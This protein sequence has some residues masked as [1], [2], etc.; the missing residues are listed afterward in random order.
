RYKKLRPRTSKTRS[1]MKLLMLRHGQ[2]EMF[3]ASDAARQL[4]DAG[5]AEVR[6][7][8]RKSEK[9]L[10]EV[11]QMWVSPLLRAQQ[12]ADLVIEARGDIPRHTTELLL[13][14]STPT[15]VMEQLLL[16][17]CGHQSYMLVGYKPLIGELVNGLCGKPNGYYPMGT[18]ALAHVVM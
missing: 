14:E 8:L 3:A 12:T 18:G 15:D 7:V 10:M 6:D 4:T 11:S 17:L 16:E 1:P 2:A 9:E 5:H 13:A